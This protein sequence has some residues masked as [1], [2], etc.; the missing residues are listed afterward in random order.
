[1]VMD[2]LKF[3]HEFYCPQYAIYDQPSSF[4]FPFEKN[5]HGKIVGLFWPETI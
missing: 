3:T 2:K 4:S 1:M 5:S